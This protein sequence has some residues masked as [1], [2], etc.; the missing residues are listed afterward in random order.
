MISSTTRSVGPASSPTLPHSVSGIALFLSLA[1]PL[2]SLPPVLSLPQSL[3]FCS[4][5]TLT[6]WYPLSLSLLSISR[7]IANGMA[8]L[9]NF[10]P[11][12][13]HCDLTSKNVLLD[14]KMTAKISDLGL[15]RFKPTDL[16]MSG[17][18]WW[19]APEMLRKDPNFGPKVDIYSYVP[20]LI[21]F[22]SCLAFCS[23]YLH[24]HFK[25]LSSPPPPPPP[26]PLFL[27]SHLTHRYLSASESSY[28]RSGPASTLA[29]STP[30]SLT[31]A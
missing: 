16:E 13:L 11:P 8:F 9:H 28:G 24:S 21:S 10:V 31:T 7:D 17:H 29:F 2:F 6:L 18:C 23:L 27:C 26:P 14:D 19:A 25:R 3:S 4:L 20:P 15:S 22:A 12:I 1:F 30:P 5:R